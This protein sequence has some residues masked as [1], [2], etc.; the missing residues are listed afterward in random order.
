MPNKQ[1]G[2]DNSKMNKYVEPIYIDIW[3]I[4]DIDWAYCIT[5]PVF[6]T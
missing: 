2:L 6:L 3:L 1:T 4:I 5:L